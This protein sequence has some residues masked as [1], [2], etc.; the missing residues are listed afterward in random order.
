MTKTA[1]LC[2]ATIMAVA[3]AGPALAQVTKP[4]LWSMTMKI[5]GMP[6]MPDIPPEALAQMRALG[7]Q[8]PAMAPGGGITTQV[9]ITPQMA[10]AS[11]APPA[12]EGCRNENITRAGN[13]F[14]GTMVCDNAQMKGTG[15]FESTSVSDQQISSKMTFKGTMQGKPAD[16]M[17][18][19]DGRW[20]AADCG[21]VRPPQA[22]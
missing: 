11:E 3:F 4:G 14:K 16:M 9:C 6:A 13:T 1:W 8:M 5:P 19:V 20:M 22:R 10:A 18:D 21:N 2:G 7:I 17:M 12:A 15:T